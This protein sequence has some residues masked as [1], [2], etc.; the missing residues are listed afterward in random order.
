[1]P[2]LTVDLAPARTAL[3]E[4]TTALVAAV[5]GLAELDLL[6]ASRCHG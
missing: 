6:G 3:R 1:M 2:A 4:S 5:D